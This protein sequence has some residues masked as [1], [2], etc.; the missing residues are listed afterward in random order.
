MLGLTR[1]ISSEDRRDT[2]MFRKTRI[3]VVLFFLFSVFL[4]VIL[5]LAKV[6][7]TDRTMP[8][9]EMD[10]ESITISVKG[11]DEAI[12]EGVT[13]KD[14]KD[15][16]LT[17][18][19]FIESKGNF[20]E[21]GRLNVVIAVADKD[22]HVAKATREVIYN[23][24]RSPQ[25]S[26]KSPMKFLIARENQ[27]DI[28]IAAGLSAR[29]VL[30]GNISNNIKFSSEY[31][32][33]F[34]SVGDYHMEFTVANSVGDTVELPVTITIYNSTQ[35]R[36]LPQIILSDYLINTPVGTNVDIE[37]LIEQI[38]YHNSIYRRGEDGNYYSGEFDALGNAIMFPSDSVQIDADINWNIPGVYEVKITFT[39]SNADIS[40]F[41]RCYISIYQ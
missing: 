35:E 13:A 37:S 36:G 23:D 3:F 18:D 7:L 9:I 32:V 11:G 15:G 33:N 2:Y 24:Y 40:N 6:A 22:N 20:I 26:L 12:L 28:N 41:V 29:D 21:K 39:D 25:F 8:V 1:G 17:D 34:F 16:D 14:S 19:L 38:E 4:F 5:R 10:S 27:D 31:S 30:D